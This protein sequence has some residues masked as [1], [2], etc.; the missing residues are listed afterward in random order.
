MDG[1]ERY[2]QHNIWR[3]IASGSDK[4]KLFL[5]WIFIQKRKN[6]GSLNWSDVEMRYSKTRS[7]Q[8][9]DIE[10]FDISF[11]KGWIRWIESHA[12]TDSYNSSKSHWQIYN[13]LF[14]VYCIKYIF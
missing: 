13:A 14:E 7:V 6:K 1:S 5:A 3:V 11:V 9:W 12:E 10:S 4:K 2:I 8:K